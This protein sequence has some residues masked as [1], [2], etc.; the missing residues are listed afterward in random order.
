MTPA[1]EIAH[2]RRRCEAHE[3]RIAEL[4]AQIEAVRIDDSLQTFAR[5]RGFLLPYQAV[6]HR[7]LGAISRLI[8]ALTTARIGAISRYRVADLAFD[9]DRDKDVETL[10]LGRV[11]VSTLRATIRAVVEAGALPGAGLPPGGILP[12]VWGAGYVVDQPTRAIARRV[13]IAAGCEGVKP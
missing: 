1:Q 6:T 10:N 11:Y 12:T 9:G 5:V 13:L 2:W 7:R 4:E 3:A 8:I